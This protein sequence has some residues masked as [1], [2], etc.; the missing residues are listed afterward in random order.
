MGRYRVKIINTFT[1]EALAL[2]SGLVSFTNRAEATD[3]ATKWKALSDETDCEIL[4]TK[5]GRTVIERK[6]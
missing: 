6:A 3:W 2:P 1:K 4:D 5:T